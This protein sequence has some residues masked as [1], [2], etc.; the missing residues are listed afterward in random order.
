M[1][2]SAPKLRNF[3][4]LWAEIQALPEGM[5]G[6]ILEPGEVHVT[7]G[8]PGRPH[9][10]SAKRMLLALGSFDVDQGGSGWWIEVE[11]EVRFGPRMLDPDLAGWRVE[12]LAHMPRENP[13]SIRPDWACE[14][15]SPSTARTDRKQKLPRYIAESVPWVWLVDPVLH[16]IE[17]YEPDAKGRPALALTAA[18][19]DRMALPPF[20]GELDVGA[21]WLR[22]EPD[23]A[24]K[25]AIKATRKT[26]RARQR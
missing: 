20:E 21:F 9:R 19:G 23:R 18:E 15:L 25:P 6:E 24:R 26:R 12:H 4:E 3:D 1:T 22:D 14:I 5:T 7:M 17:V 11:P 8:R 10:F 2:A 16:L 13:I